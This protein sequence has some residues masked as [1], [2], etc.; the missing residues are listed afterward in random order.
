[1]FK[2]IVGSYTAEGLIRPAVRNAGTTS[3][4]ARPRREHV[5]A[6]FGLS[7][8][9][10]VQLCRTFGVPPNEVVGGVNDEPIFDDPYADIICE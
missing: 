1:M 2:F 10:A 4:Q 5:K 9:N 8:A 6:L 7:E 3:A